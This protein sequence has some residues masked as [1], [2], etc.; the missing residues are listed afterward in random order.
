MADEKVTISKKIAPGKAAP[1]PERTGWVNVYDSSGK[2]LLHCWYLNVCRLVSA[3][4]KGGSMVVFH[5]DAGAGWE[6]V[7]VGV[8]A[9]HMAIVAAEK[10]LEDWRK[11]ERERKAATR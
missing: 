10:A 4:E 9:M 1:D 5:R 7:P 11:A 6:L 3:P 8:R 2:M